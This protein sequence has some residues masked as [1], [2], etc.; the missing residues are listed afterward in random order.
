MSQLP[1]DI[2]NKIHLYN[3]HPCADMIRELKEEAQEDNHFIEDYCIY[4]LYGTYLEY[5]AK[6][7][8]HI[9]HEDY[10]TRLFDRLKSYLK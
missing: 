5:C 6:Y 8:Y 10:K 3:S 4:H 2:W 1:Q 9:E 7:P